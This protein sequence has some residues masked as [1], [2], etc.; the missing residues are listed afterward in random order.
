MV[1]FCRERGVRESLFYAWKRRIREAEAGQFVE[2]KVAAPEEAR[3]P[4]QARDTTIEIRLPKG[5]S[6]IVDPGFDA[7]HLRA[8]LAVL[9]SVS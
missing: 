3:L 6:L 7:H 4:E 9:D 1:V 2:V 5:R 8:V